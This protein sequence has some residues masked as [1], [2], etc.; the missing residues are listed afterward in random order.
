[1]AVV[2]APVIAP[3]S[4]CTFCSITSVFIGNLRNVDGSGLPQTLGRGRPAHLDVR[5]AR[6]GGLSGELPAIS[7]FPGPGRRFP[8]PTSG[9]LPSGLA[10]QPV[11]GD[12]RRVL[13][14]RVHQ[15]LAPA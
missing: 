4:R 6:P 1:M 13:G 2:A 10:E 15:Q 5:T 3:S 11:L 8:V 14:P 12:P 9:E 7:R